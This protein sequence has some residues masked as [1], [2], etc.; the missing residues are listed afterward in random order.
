VNECKPLALGVQEPEDKNQDEDI[1]MAPPAFNI[2]DVRPPMHLFIVP[3]VPAQFIRAR[4]GGTPIMLAPLWSRAAHE[5]AGLWVWPRGTEPLTG[6]IVNNRFLIEAYIASGSYGH[7]WRAL[8]LHDPQKK[9]KFLKTPRA[10]HDY[11]PSGMMAELARELGRGLH[12]ST[13]Q[14]SLTRSD[15]KTHPTHALIVPNNP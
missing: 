12:S 7:G 15:T 5:P 2:E 3:K 6:A 10:S 4:D 14:L 11:M 9:A 8:D 13:F 1:A